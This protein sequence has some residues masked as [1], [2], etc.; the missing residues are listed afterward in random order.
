MYELTTS[1]NI[2]AQGWKTPE[3]KMPYGIWHQKY[4][5]DK[6]ETKWVIFP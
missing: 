4:L 3:K 5:D 2:K 1:P 6:G